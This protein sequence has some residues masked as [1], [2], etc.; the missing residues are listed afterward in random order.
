MAGSENGRPGGN[1][2]PVLASVA[3]RLKYAA[4]SEREGRSPAR[5]WFARASAPATR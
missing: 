1:A 3:D 4:D 5:V 2:N